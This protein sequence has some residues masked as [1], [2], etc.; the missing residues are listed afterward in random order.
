MKKKGL[1][2]IRLLPVSLKN[3]NLEKIGTFLAVIILQFPGLGT[4]SVGASL[5]WLFYVL[6]PHF[7]FG[8]G[9]Y[10]MATTVQKVSKNTIHVQSKE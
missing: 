8:H 10:L 6:I 2:K 1:Q 4:A 3:L 5:K 9:L 7:C